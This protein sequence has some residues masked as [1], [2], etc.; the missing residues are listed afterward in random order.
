MSLSNLCLKTATCGG[1]VKQAAAAASSWP[2]ILFVLKLKARS[3]CNISAFTKFTAVSFSRGEKAQ[4]PQMG[5]FFYDN[6]AEV[7]EH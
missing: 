4:P 2:L 7:A 3:C 5:K 6:S 1:E